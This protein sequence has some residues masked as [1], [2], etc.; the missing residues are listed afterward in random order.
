VNRD[1]DA[2]DCTCAACLQDRD[3]ASFRAGAI[4]ASEFVI[5]GPSSPSKSTARMA[6]SGS[7]GRRV[8]PTG[9]TRWLRSEPGSGMVH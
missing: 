4:V 2:N 6:W 3:Q 5:D 1:Q 7:S 8:R 9:P